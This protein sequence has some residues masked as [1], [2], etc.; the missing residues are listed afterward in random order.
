MI[1]QE[2]IYHYKDIGTVV[3]RK[4]T[5]VK[6]LGIRV[7]PSGEIFVTIPFYISLKSAEEF[8]VSKKD[9]IL[10]S[11]EKL[12]SVTNEKLLFNDQTEYHTCCHTLRIIRTENNKPDKRISIPY[13]EVL[14]PFTENIESEHCQLFIKNAITEAYRKEAI[15]NLPQRLNHYAQEYSFHYSGVSI[16]KMKSRWGSCSGKNKISLN[17]YLMTLPGHLR[18]YVILHEL[19]HTVEKN[20]GKE[21]WNKLEN[22]CPE[23]KSYRKEIQHYRADALY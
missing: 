18:D 5:G 16:K 20:H 14:I 8:L 23:A 19:V 13:I 10:R 4:K 2:K 17:L 21:F 11:R 6:R 12:L 22:V 9:W 7:K 3:Y 1:Q 15:S